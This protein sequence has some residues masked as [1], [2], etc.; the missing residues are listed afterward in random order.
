M[1]DSSL[2]RCAIIAGI[3]SLAAP[4]LKAQSPVQIHPADGSA[5]GLRKI[6]VL[7]DHFTSAEEATFNLAAANFITYGLL[8]DPYF[9]QHQS[10]FTVKTLFQ[11]WISGGAESNYGFVVGAGG[12][13]SIGWDEANTA[14]LVIK[15]AG[16]AFPDDA[17]DGIVVIGNH[18]YSFG[19]TG[20]RLWT[21]VAIGA[22][23]S[24]VLAHE[25]GHLLVGLMDEF[26][27]PANINT[28]HPAPVPDFLNCSPAPDPPHW[29]GPGS[30]GLPE[31]NLYGLGVV[32][33]TDRCRMGATGGDFCYVCEHALGI[34]FGVNPDTSNPTPPNRGPSNP[35]A[36]N[37]RNITPPPPTPKPKPPTGVKISG[38]GFFAA[39]AAQDPS[40]Q[41]VRV[42]VQVRN[43]SATT[44]VLRAVDVKGPAVNER[45]RR[46]YYIYEISEAGKPL[47]VGMIAGDPFQARG[48]GGF[49]PRHSAAPS[50]T[51]TVQVTIPGVTRQV[52][53]TRN[54]EIAVYRITGQLGAATIDL[55]RF[56]Q[57]RAKNQVTRIAEVTADTLREAAR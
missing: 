2:F 51:G 52:L 21:Y 7:A 49:S 3:C 11:P 4:S 46:G 32:H 55:D 29:G 14:A 12:D 57:L 18:N 50:P 25:F 10:A 5:G 23:G 42:L 37:P 36:L 45:V 40:T 38:A 17:V 30:G 35:D 54:I 44:R 41:S 48:Y 8:A 31:C 27:L 33:P 1:T 20:D 13:C 9:A 34:Y 53:L 22:V 43:G 47:A 26:S 39:L 24:D 15:A 28:Q 19:C 56:I 6:A 16:L